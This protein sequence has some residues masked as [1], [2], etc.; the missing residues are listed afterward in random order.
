MVT[1]TIIL[2]VIFFWLC[3]FLAN[4]LR[5]KFYFLDKWLVTM[6]SG[7]VHT[8][9]YEGS[10][11]RGMGNIVI[12]S[13]DGQPFSVLVCIRF[14]ILPGIYW[15]IDPYSMV[16]SSAKGVVITNTYL[17][18]NPVTFTYVANRKVGLTITSN[19][20]D[21]SLV[22]DVVHKPHLIQWLF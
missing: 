4:E 2:S 16:I 12:R 14:Y 7:M 18:C 17:G 13:D 10:C 1:V 5:K 22:A 6:E 8:Y 19:A 3:F 11:S 9:Q 20:E 15:G 21:Q